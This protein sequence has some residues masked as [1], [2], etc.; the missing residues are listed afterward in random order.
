MGLCSVMVPVGSMLSSGL[1]IV[2]KAFVNRVGRGPVVC[3]G[4]NIFLFFFAICHNSWQGEA[5]G[6][7]IYIFL[8]LTM[9]CNWHTTCLRW[10][11]KQLVYRY[12]N[13]L[14]IVIKPQ[15]EIQM[16]ILISPLAT[17]SGLLAHS[18]AFFGCFLFLPHPSPLGDTEEEA[19]LAPRQDIRDNREELFDAFSNNCQDWDS[20]VRLFVVW[21]WRRLS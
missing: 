16:L 3:I 11:S 14:S 2:F 21:R 13:N 8:G 9:I 7:V 15:K 20:C 6:V 17:F 12:Q 18:L 19:F 4:L 5:L 10:L 1:L